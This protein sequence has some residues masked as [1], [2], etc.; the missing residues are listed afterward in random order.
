MPA[1]HD[2][3]SESGPIPLSNY[4]R[5]P[6]GLEQATLPDGGLNVFR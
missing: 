5:N 6:Q 1:G 2:V 3:F 4:T